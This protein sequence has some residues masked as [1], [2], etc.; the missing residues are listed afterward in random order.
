MKIFENA[1]HKNKKLDDFS[2]LCSNGRIQSIYLLESSY[3]KNWN[4]FRLNV[5]V[6]LFY[7]KEFELGKV[8][9]MILKEVIT[10]ASNIF[11]I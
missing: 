11:I 2:A 4:I 8:E 3:K 5:N 10:S 1:D 7:L 9:V 6:S